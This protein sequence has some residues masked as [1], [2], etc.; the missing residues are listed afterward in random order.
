MR[1]ADSDEAGRLLEWVC[2]MAAAMGTG[3]K[4]RAAAR[5][6][7]SP[8][9]FS[10]M[11]HVPNRSFDRKTMNAVAWI[12][13]AHNETDVPAVVERKVID[14]YCFEWR[15]NGEWTWRVRG[16]EESI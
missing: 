4:A 1:R 9:A 13:S 11:L 3:G 15:E 14:G 12:H 2:G 8:S 5:L 10:H 16:E 6:N 7:I